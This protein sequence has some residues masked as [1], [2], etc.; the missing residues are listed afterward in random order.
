MEAHNGKHPS[1]KTEKFCKIS[2]VTKDFLNDI[3]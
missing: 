1:W 2:Y 3:A